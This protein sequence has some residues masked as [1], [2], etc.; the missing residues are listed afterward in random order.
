[1]GRQSQVGRW[2]CGG[3]I[4]LHNLRAGKSYKILLLY[5]LYCGVHCRRFYL[6]S[7]RRTALYGARVVAEARFVL[8]V[9]FA[10]AEAN[11]VKL[12]AVVLVEGNYG[13]R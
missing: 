1:M 3:H 6:I 12:G 8:S 9:L 5:V 13:T 4:K 11:T 2:V 7:G 10:S